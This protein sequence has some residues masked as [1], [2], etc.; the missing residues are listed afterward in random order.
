MVTKTDPKTKE[1]KILYPEL[2]VELCGQTFTIRQWAFNKAR[3]NGKKLTEP[4]LKLASGNTEEDLIAAI[5]DSSYEAACEI[6]AEDFEL[7]MET[8]ENLPGVEAVKAFKGILEVNKSFFD[9]LSEIQTMLPK[10]K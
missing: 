6:I 3:K 8:V 9:G 10:G 4:F 7:D 5:F 2:D 1:F